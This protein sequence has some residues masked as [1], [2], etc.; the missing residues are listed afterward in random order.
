LEI[1]F[2]GKSPFTALEEWGASVENEVIPLLPDCSSC[3]YE[4]F[5]EKIMVGLFFGFLHHSMDKEI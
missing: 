2:L 3:Y 5:H 1:S 4:E